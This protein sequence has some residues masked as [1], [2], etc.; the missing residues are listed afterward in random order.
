MTDE[1]KKLFAEKTMTAAE[2]AALVKDG[3]TVYIGTCTSVAYEIA[4]KL[5]ER[6]EAGELGKIRVG[7][8]NIFKDLALMESPE[9]VR[10]ASSFMGP[11]ERKALKCGALE[12]T[13]I[14]LSQVDLFYHDTWPTDI[15]FI[16][17]SLPDE[18]GYMS[19]GATGVAM[20]PFVLDSAKTIILQINKYAPYVYGTQN[21]VHISQADG[22][23]YF[24]EEPPAV[25]NTDE[26]PEVKKISE[27]I[28]DRIPDGACVQLGIG[29]IGNSVGYGL[30]VRN[31]LGL[32]TE[33][34]TDSMAYLMKNGNVTN[35]CK[36][37]MPG[38]T[39]AS[40][41]LGS[42]ELYHFIDHNPDMFY[43]PFP[44]VNDPRL[45]SLN[46]NAVSINSA[47]EIDLYGQVVADNI[48]G[49]QF[50]GVG[51]QL[52]FVK[53]V[54]MAKGG[55]SFIAVTST[56]TNRAGIRRS[57]IVSRLAEGSVVTTP[58]AEVQHVV[59]EYGLV[60][61]KKLTQRGRAEALISLAHPDYRDQ[62]REDAKKLRLL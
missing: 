58:R 8:S 40:F 7:C 4:R 33:M 61:L 25:D 22:V 6:V 15:A 41:T 34:M 62:L 23:V 53:G 52:D 43:Q 10:V 26:T 31:D 54:Q 37:Y 32:H 17:V 29:N 13:S 35:R 49:R 51:G 59:T 57:R 18:D 45:I 50:S 55:Q 3:D 24:D 44:I 56:N 16:D 28:I 9:H 11:G 2:A 48:A 38:K 36:S 39:V 21:L 27:L 42:R 12:Y 14:H 5:G 46:D 47:I 60:N 1:L 20:H 30:H 19:L